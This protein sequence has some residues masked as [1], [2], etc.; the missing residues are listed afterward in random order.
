MGKAWANLG[1]AARRNT[2]G[3]STPCG[4]RAAQ[5]KAEQLRDLRMFTSGWPAALNH[6]SA[7]WAHPSA[8]QE[9]K[10][11]PRP[12]PPA[13]QAQIHFLNMFYSILLAEK[14]VIT[15]GYM[16]LYFS[17]GVLT[18]WKNMEA[19]KTG[20]NGLVDLV[21]SMAEMPSMPSALRT[22]GAVQSLEHLAEGAPRAGIPKKLPSSRGGIHGC[23]WETFSHVC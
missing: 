17:S 5:R 23:C 14:K 8:L 12:T 10:R 3:L 22:W 19:S 18:K 16:F 20:L 11:N 13:L 7:F 1:P 2:R 6:P 15:T 4:L 9:K 21:F